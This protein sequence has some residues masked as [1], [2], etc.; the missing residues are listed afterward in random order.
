[1]KYS[2]FILSLVILTF[3]LVSLI[4]FSFINEGEMA[5]TFALVIIVT[6]LLNIPI[7]GCHLFRRKGCQ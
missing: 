4:W 1:M 5:D 6:G 2:S 3:F 7:K